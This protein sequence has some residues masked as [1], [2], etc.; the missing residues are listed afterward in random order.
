MPISVPNEAV[1][2]PGTVLLDKYEVVRELGRGGMA[3]VYEAMHR[4]LGQPIAVKVLAAELIKSS[5]VK[6]RFIREARAVAAIKSA[7]IVDVYDTGVLA[8]GRPYIAMELL[9][10]ETLYERLASKGRIDATETAAIVRDCAAGLQNAHDVGIVHRD[11]KPENIFLCVGPSGQQSAKLLDFGLAK[12]H[13]AMGEEAGRLT[14]DGAVFGTPAYMSPEQLKGQA[15]VDHRADLW[16]LG[17]ITYEC[18]TGRSVWATNQSMAMTFAAIATAALP[19][20]TDFRPDAP[21]AF[22]DWFTRALQRDPAKR[23]QSARALSE[24]LAL[25]FSSDLVSVDYGLPAPGNAFDV[26]DEPAVA[27]GPVPIV[28][29]IIRKGGTAGLV[30]GALG[31]VVGVGGVSAYYMEHKKHDRDVADVRA[32]TGTQ[33][34]MGAARVQTAPTS[35]APAAVGAMPLWAK[36]LAEGQRRLA[37]GD[38]AGAALSWREAAASGAASSATGLLEQ[39]KVAS[40]GSGACSVAALG[41]PRPATSRSAGRPAVVATKAGVLVAWTDDHEHAGHEHVYASLLGEDLQSATASTTDLSP[42]ADSAFRPFFLQDGDETALVFADRSGQKPGIYTRFIDAEAHLSGELVH[43]GGD[44]PFTYYVHAHR[45]QAGYHFLWE[46]DRDGAPNIFLTHTDARLVP[47]GGVRRVT[48]FAGSGPLARVPRY[49]SGATADGQL[50]LGYALESG[51]GK[52]A[53]EAL[54]LAWPVESLPPA[55]AHAVS[56]RERAGTVTVLA[57]NK[58][59]APLLTCEGADCYVAWQAVPAGVHVTRFNPRTKKRSWDKLVSAKGT[60]PSIVANGQGGIVL[61]FVESGTVRIANVTPQGVA[62]PGVFAK[63]SVTQHR[64]YLAPGRQL[65]EWYVAWLEMENMHLE[66]YVAKLRCPR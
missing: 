37:G 30:V 17:C 24:S 14:R 19:V 44:K 62:Q 18:L 23:F 51:R 46:D 22:N 45:S 27:S 1:I 53:L 32:A 50:V 26:R 12:V 13:T 38:S 5:V 4:G 39:L 20:P 25:A 64:P 11:L 60:T 42:E 36:Q 2:P 3:V 16:A 10:G 58:V 29:T 40:T 59:D 41:H 8:D 54:S 35:N 57:D 48:S 65:G 43:V 52:V 15:S 47:E 49:V 21:L 63:T 31:L 9:R 6:E 61:A 55:S 33:S 34:V 28:T 56:K 66:P 7:H